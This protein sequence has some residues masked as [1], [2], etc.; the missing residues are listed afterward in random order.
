MVHLPFSHLGKYV[1]NWH[2]FQQAQLFFIV[3]FLLS[4]IKIM[5]KIIIITF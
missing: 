3:L 1:S 5:D 2:W 4:N